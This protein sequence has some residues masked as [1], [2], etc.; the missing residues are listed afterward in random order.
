MG[1]SVGTLGGHDMGISLRKG[2]LH[3]G[4]TRPLL[5]VGQQV[6]DTRYR[7][8]VVTVDSDYVVNQLSSAGSLLGAG[9]GPLT[10]EG[11]SGLLGPWAQC[12]LSGTPGEDREFSSNGCRKAAGALCIF[13]WSFMS[14]CSHP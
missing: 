13:V 4:Q 9:D 1:R 5:S 6:A 10:G 2:S 8:Q 7:T 11:T 14:H 3:P 12:G